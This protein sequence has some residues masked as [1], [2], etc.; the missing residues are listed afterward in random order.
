MNPFKWTRSEKLRGIVGFLLLLIVLTTLMSDLE[1]GE[2][3]P[4]LT[5]VSAA[6]IVTGLLPARR[7]GREDVPAVVGG[8]AAASVGVGASVFWLWD[9]T[10]EPFEILAGILVGATVILVFSLILTLMIWGANT[11]SRPMEPEYIR[12]RRLIVRSV[13]RQLSEVVDEI[14]YRRPIGTDTTTYAQYDSQMFLLFLHNWS[15]LQNEWQTSY[16][17]KEHE[18]LIGS[19]LVERLLRTAKIAVNNHPHQ[20]KYGEVAQELADEANLFLQRV[21]IIKDFDPL[22]DTCPE[23]R[24]PKPSHKANCMAAICWQCKYPTP[25]IRAE[26]TN[27]TVITPECHISQ[28][29]DPRGEQATP[30]APILPRIRLPFTIPQSSNDERLPVIQLPRGRRQRRDL[31]KQL[32]EVED[33]IQ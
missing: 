22:P 25:P 21:N 6:L 13:K 32:Q 18:N 20:C 8:V 26:S 4:V 30:V 17:P 29:C 10:E 5:M 16:A 3:A 23:C 19:Y 28:L 7:L 1:E 12:R 2:K 15:M 31:L 33:N 14:R 24:E 11:F 27:E 9:A